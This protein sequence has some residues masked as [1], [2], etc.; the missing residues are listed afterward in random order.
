MAQDCVAQRVRPSAGEGSSLNSPRRAENGLGV[1]GRCSWL[2]PLMR[3]HICRIAAVAECILAMVCQ[4]VVRRQCRPAPRTSAQ[5]VLHRGHVYVFGGEVCKIPSYICQPECTSRC[6][7]TETSREIYPK[8]HRTCSEGLCRAWR[9][10]GSGGGKGGCRCAPRRASTSGT[11]GICGGWTWRRF[12]GRSSQA[13]PPPHW[14]R[15]APACLVVRGC[16][17][18]RATGRQATRGGWGG[19][20]SQGRPLCSVG[21]PHGAVE[22]AAAGLRRLLQRCQGVQAGPPSPACTNR[23]PMLLS[24]VVWMVRGVSLDLRLPSARVATGGCGAARYFNDVWEYDISELTWRQVLPALL[25]RAP[26][27]PCC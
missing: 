22:G 3:I 25:A 2:T 16:S 1:L 15:S 5:A 21:A 7:A 12:P 10:N 26:G 11:T 6:A 8:M 17:W 19:R 20:C 13:P 23:K 18:Q 24:W 9:M 4:L 14:D 27:A